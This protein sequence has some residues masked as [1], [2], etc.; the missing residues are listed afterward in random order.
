M[1]EHE[2]S[3]DEAGPGMPR[4][5]KVIGL[6]LAVV[7][8]LALLAQLTGAAGNHGPGRH[9]SIGLGSAGYVCAAAPASGSGR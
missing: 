2:A 7:A 3:R 4:W 8:A 5:V 6:V 9:L 1:A